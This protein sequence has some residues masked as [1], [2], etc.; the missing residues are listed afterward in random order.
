MIDWDKIRDGDDPEYLAEILRLRR[1]HHRRVLDAD[2]AEYRQELA[3][4]RH[5]SWIE[6]LEGMEEEG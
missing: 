5:G 3:E 2:D 6:Q 4:G 1:D